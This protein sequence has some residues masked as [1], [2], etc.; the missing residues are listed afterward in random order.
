[1]CLAQ[2]VELASKKLCFLSQALHE[3]DK[4]VTTPEVVTEGSETQYHL[5][6]YRKFKACLGYMRNYLK[7][8]EVI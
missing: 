4:V 6:L 2:L 5:W 8:V 7:R 1:M 3:L